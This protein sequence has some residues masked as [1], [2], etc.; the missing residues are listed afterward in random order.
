MI[1]I[2]D[3]VV[4]LSTGANHDPAADCAASV[5]SMFGAHLAAVAFAYDPVVPPTFM[6]EV[7]PADLI[8]SQ[9][10]EA[11][12]KAKAA[13]A[14][15]EE[16]AR[17]EGI[18]VQTGILN[19]S[20]VGAA[21]LFSRI[22]RRFDLSIVKQGE[23]DKAEPQDLLIEGA[24]FESGRPVLVVPYIHKGALKLERAMICWDGSRAAARAVGD[25][26]PILERSKS[27]EVVVVVGERGKSDELPGAD[28]G[29][30]L[31]RHG[32]KVE[33][34][35]IVSGDLDVANTILSHAADNAT[36]F[37]VMGGYGHSRL[38]EFVLGGVTRAILETMTVPTLM[39]H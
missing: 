2:K 30:H 18:S 34:K 29:H 37:I 27:I 39:S 20:L 14:K 16:R 13:V 23:A 36:D 11:E 15:L 38:R 19:A 24:L 7:I 21:D 31:A 17:R 35:R 1:M 22:A 33:V 12:T 26:L 5:A 9:R 3:I 8:E 6:G 4:H 28:I 32:L 10:Q 25:A